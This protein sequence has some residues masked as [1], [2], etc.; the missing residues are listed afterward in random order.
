MTGPSPTPRSEP[1][2]RNRTCAKCGADF[3]VKFPSERKR[4]CSYSCSAK[5]RPPKNDAANP[6]WRGGKTKH[7]LYDIY[8][9]MISRC[10]RPTHQRYADYGG[11]GITVCERWRDDFWAFVADMG[12]RPEGLTL[13]RENNGNGYSPDNCRWATYSEQVNN[14]RPLPSRFSGEDRAAMQE[15]YESGLSL[16]KVA[17][18][19]GTNSAYVGVL[20]R[21]LGTQMRPSSPCKLTNA[22]HAEA[23]ALYQSG[24]SQRELAVRY[25]V[26]R[27]TI[28][29]IVNEPEET[30]A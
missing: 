3:T 30:A 16:T 13:D 28:N 29:R 19:F 12:E 14:R 6:N 8:R 27:S 11:R 7:P 9:D 23:R 21:E 5:A 24:I 10:Y 20:L 1:D 2:S 15:M 26:A 22:E 17:E 4:Y 18:H 25:G